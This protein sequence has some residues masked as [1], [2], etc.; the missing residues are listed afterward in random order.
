MAG[1]TATPHGARGAD[2]ATGGLRPVPA[3]TIPTPLHAGAFMAKAGQDTMFEQL[4]HFIRRCLFWLASL[5]DGR[6]QITRADILQAEALRDGAAA[7]SIEDAVS[8]DRA[9]AARRYLGELQ[10]PD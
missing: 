2:G 5:G 8:L 7:G 1:A 3:R 9:V 10:W 6:N 4:V